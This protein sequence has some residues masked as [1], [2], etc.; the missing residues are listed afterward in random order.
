MGYGKEMCYR[1]AQW[2]H[3]LR[4]QTDDRQTPERA[5]RVSA[6]FPDPRIVLRRP[7]VRAD[8]PEDERRGDRESQDGSPS[9]QQPFLLQQ[10]NAPLRR[11]ASTHR[12]TAETL[13]VPA[14]LG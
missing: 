2:F 4:R 7:R 13:P 12:R 10:Q 1:I 9:R 5:Q 14:P 6:R 11:R 3:Y 8:E